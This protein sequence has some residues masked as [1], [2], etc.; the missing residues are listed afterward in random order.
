MF[1]L[2]IESPEFVGKTKI[3]QHKLVNQLLKEDIKSLHG[4][5][6]ETSVPKK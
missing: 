3:E 1:R 5:T 2:K 4:F 6:L